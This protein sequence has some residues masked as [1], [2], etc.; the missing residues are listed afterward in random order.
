MET[1]L[2]VRVATIIVVVAVVVVVVDIVPTLG[3]KFGIST[4]LKIFQSYK[5][6]PKVA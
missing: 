2:R 5:L 1:T 3:S 6:Y 4:L